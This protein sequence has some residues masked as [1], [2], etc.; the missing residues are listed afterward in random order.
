MQLRLQDLKINFREA[1][2]DLELA[3]IREKISIA[4]IEKAKSIC[5]RWDINTTERVRRHRKM[6]NRLEMLVFLQKVK[7]LVL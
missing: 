3:E 1:F 6:E 2:H 4:A 7:F 5:K